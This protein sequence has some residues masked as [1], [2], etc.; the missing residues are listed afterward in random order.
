MA[1]KIVNGTFTTDLAGWR[2]IGAR[3]F[4]WSAGTAR[5][6]SALSGVTTYSFRLAQSF[7]KYQTVLSAVLSVKALYD[8]VAGDTDGSNSFSVNLK[9]PSGALVNLADAT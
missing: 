3:P 4:G 9:K 2:N 1:D 7:A 5:G 6:V 8:S